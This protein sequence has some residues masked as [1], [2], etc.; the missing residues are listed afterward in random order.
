MIY[1]KNIEISQRQYI[2]G[3]DTFGFSPTEESELM[4]IEEVFPED[5]REDWE[6]K[7]E[8][9]SG[10]QSVFLAVDN[11]RERMIAGEAYTT[12]KKEDDDGD[13]DVRH[14]NDI[15]DLCLKEEGVYLCSL[16]VLPGYEGID[17][18]KRMMMSIIIDSKKN[19]FKCIYSHAHE[20]GSRHLHEFF[21]A[22]ILETRKNWFDTGDNYYLC[23][24]DISAINLIDLQPFIQE[25]NY[26]CGTATLESIFYHK[27]GQSFGGFK[28]GDIEKSSE[29]TKDGTEPIGMSKAL[30]MAGFNPEWV[31]SD[32]QLRTHI[33]YRNPVAIMV[34]SPGCYEGHWLT[35]VGT[36]KKFVYVQDVSDGHFGRMS[37][38]ELNRVWWSN[39][40]HSRKG[41]V[42]LD[43]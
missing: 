39:E 10:A 22:E 40:Y 41:I 20:G 8:V 1:N 36:S 28:R 25:T 30:G 17:I 13:E 11:D 12:L 34:L 9:M 23:K 26:D 31:S 16:A 21:G 35:V 29:L 42:A 37:W 18:A 4:A 6:G 38:N 32:Q 27:F 2:L 7:S 19:G 24:I 15:I 14:Y 5:I 33:L 43:F 3:D